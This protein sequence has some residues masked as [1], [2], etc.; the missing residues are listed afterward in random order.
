[1]ESIA[2]SVRQTLSRDLSMAPVMAIGPVRIDPP[3]RT[4]SSVNGTRKLEPRVMR[5]LV[6]LAEAR[7]EVL[8]RD[9]L[10][11]LARDGVIVGDNAINRVVSQLRKV[12]LELAGDSVRL[13]T[14]TKVG[15]RLVADDWTPAAVESTPHPP[16]TRA[17]DRRVLLGGAAAAGAGLLGLGGWRMLRG[18]VPD[19]R[20]RELWE[21]GQLT[22]KTGEPG[23]METAMGFYKQAVAIDPDY[24]DA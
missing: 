20:A 15:F 8:S 11:E 1:M 7:G 12:L 21:H 23:T 18:H 9:D 19:P 13:E 16:A 4:I 24:A 5:T 3:T 14:I 2:I 22:Q 17:F 6:V 10:I